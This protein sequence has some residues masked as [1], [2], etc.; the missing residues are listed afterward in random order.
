VDTWLSKEK[1]TAAAPG[2]DAA[3]AGTETL[4]SKIRIALI[5]AIRLVSLMGIWPSRA[6]FA[7]KTPIQINN[8]YFIILSR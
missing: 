2:G 1:R 8:I 5:D 3:E 4:V 6:L 7:V